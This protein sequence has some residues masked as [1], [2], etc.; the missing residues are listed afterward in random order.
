[1][2]LFRI[3]V[4]T[5]SLLYAVGIQASLL[6]LRIYTDEEKTIKIKEGVNFI[7]SLKSNKTT[8]YEWRL[9][10]PMEGTILALESSQYEPPKTKRMGAGG[11]EL[12]TFRAK[13][14]GE[15]IVMFHYVRPWENDISPTRKKAFKI[16]VK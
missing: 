16:I 1:M 4:I 8:G 6:S 12:W 13:Q 11:R 9:A 7:I 3:F 5:G 2:K 10:S 15:I 14:K